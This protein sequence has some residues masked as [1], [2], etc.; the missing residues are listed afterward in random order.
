MK[1]I[2]QCFKSK[3]K[4]QPAEMMAFYLKLKPVKTM[5]VYLC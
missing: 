3:G 4:I 5:A 2:F 1:R